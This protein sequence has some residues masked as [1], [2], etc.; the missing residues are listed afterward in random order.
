MALTA[1]LN[2]MEIC[3]H[4][5]ATVGRTDKECGACHRG[6]T[7][8][9]LLSPTVARRPETVSAGAILL[10]LAALAAGAV[11]LMLLVGGPTIGIG[12]AVGLGV[13]GGGC[14][15]AVLARIVQAGA[16]HAEMIAALRQ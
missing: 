12:A 13:I 3:P 16:H 4:C 5:G 11:G 15:F 6:L 7:G 2:S 1:A 10:I 14:L 9:A 8:K